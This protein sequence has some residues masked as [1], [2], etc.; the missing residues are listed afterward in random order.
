MHLNTGKAPWTGIA[1]AYGGILIVLASTGIFLV[2][3]RKGLQG[4]GGVVM[5]AGVLLPI[6]YALGMRN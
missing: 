2:K 4:R 3:G 6:I 5:A 1:D